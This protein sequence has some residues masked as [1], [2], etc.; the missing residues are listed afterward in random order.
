MALTQQQIAGIWFVIIVVG[1]V[2]GVALAVFSE[3]CKAIGC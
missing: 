3:I 2:I 1:A